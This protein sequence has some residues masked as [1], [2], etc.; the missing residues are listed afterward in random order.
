MVKPTV[1]SGLTFAEGGEG[2][3]V[4]SSCQLIT[5][6]SQGNRFEGG[7]KRTDDVQTLHK[8]KNYAKSKIAVTNVGGAKKRP[9]FQNDRRG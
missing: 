5:G 3:P 8:G 4:K 9:P 1:T 2:L 6:G 7:G